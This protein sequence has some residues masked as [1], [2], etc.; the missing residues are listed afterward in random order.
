MKKVVLLGDSIRMFYGKAVEEKLKPDYEVWQPEDNCR[1]A[2]YLYRMLFDYKSELEGA[3]IIH[4]NCGH[5]DLCD[6]FEDGSFTDPEMYRQMLVKI[7]NVLKKYSKNLVF[8][9]TCPVNPVYKYNSI[10]NINKFNKIAVETLEPMG[11]VIN[12]LYT[13]VWADVAKYIGEDQLHP[14][15]AGVELLSTLVADKIRSIV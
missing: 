10:E 12:D 7:T 1:F 8:A 13:P 11:V 14:S 5:W 3:D 9:L 4:W 2:Q 15:E 6:L